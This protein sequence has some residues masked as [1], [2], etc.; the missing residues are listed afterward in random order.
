MEIS[1]ATIQ[2][3]LQHMVE[4]YA[5]HEVYLGKICGLRVQLRNKD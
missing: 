3:L 2:P 5:V 1:M 4:E